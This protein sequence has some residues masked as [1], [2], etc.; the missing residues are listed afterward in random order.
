MLMLN[1]KKTVVYANLATLEMEKSIVSIVCGAL[2]MPI[3]S[4]ICKS[5]SARLVSVE[6]VF[7][8]NERVGMHCIIFNKYIFRLFFS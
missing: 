7:N 5:A 3:V 1:V 2:Q 6:M 8:A 4:R